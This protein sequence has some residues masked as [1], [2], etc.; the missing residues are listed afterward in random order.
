MGITYGC[1]PSL[2]PVWTRAL[3]KKHLSTSVR[4]LI[5]SLTSHASWSSRSSRYTRE[6]YDES[7]ESDHDDD[8]P[9]EHV[10]PASSFASA[11]Q[12]RA[13]RGTHP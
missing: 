4:N 6:G 1:M 12:R 5:S 8:S 2:A 9:L 10:C 7:K 13:A 3:S 11:A